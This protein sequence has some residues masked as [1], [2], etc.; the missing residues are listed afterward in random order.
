MNPFTARRLALTAALLSLAVMTAAGWAVTTS[1][2]EVQRPE[3]FNQGTT[4]GISIHS[5]GKVTL[6][7]AIEQLA[8]TGESFVWS[9]T[10]GSDGALYAGT[11]NNGKIIR[12]H[13]DRQE[14]VWQD[15][16]ELEIL[17]LITGPDGHLYAGTSPG[18]KVLRVSPGGEGGLLFETGEQHVWSLVFDDDGRLYAGTGTD[19]KI[20]RISADGQGELFYDTRETNVTA[21][22][23]R[24]KHLYAGGSGG[25]LIYKFDLRGEGM[26]VFDAEEEEIC[27][28]VF[29]AGGQLYAAATSG[30]R[31]VGRPPSPENGQKK[32]D[33][34]SGENEQEGGFFME[35]PPE[36]GDFG[37]QFA[38]P[39]TVYQIDGLGSGQPLWRAPEGAMIFSMTL[40]PG[41]E[42]IVGTGDE[43]RIYS[44]RAAGDWSL[45]AEMDE[46]QVL[47]LQNDGQGGILAGTGNLGAVHRLKKGYGRQGSL[48]SKVHDAAIAAQ[49]GR[50]A[51]EA[52]QPSGT[53]VT[54]VTRSGNS[55][56]PDETWSSW[57]RP[58]GEAEGQAVESPPARFIQW[59]IDLSTS[60][61]DRTPALEKVWL[62]Y[63]Q[64]NMAP[65]IQALYVHPPGSEDGSGMGSPQRGGGNSGFSNGGA[66]NSGEPF[67]TAGNEPSG[68]RKVSW[69][70]GDPNGD[71]LVFTLSFRGQEEEN[72]KLLKEDL[73]SGSYSWDSNLLPD[74]WYLLKLEVSDRLSNPE[75]QALDS[76]EISDPFVI[77]NTSPQVEVQG[78]REGERRYRISGQAVDR[79]SP[80]VELWYSL[81]AGE[82]KPL[83]VSDEIF[84]HVREEFSLVTGELSSGEHIVV[85]KALDRAGNVGVGKVVMK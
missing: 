70:A 25:G 85:V 80:I 13:G 36:F 19:G 29:D 17:S 84:D 49:W 45:V 37:M 82:W 11:G 22:V 59:R 66:S 30:E 35:E 24:G 28:L 72:W 20:F 81:D 62:A 26:M 2:W 75:Q 34:D 10:V 46:A 50:I 44:V 58:Y 78:K 3:Q 5:D 48:E 56:H 14:T 63:L 73:T 38:G 31:P 8:E 41:N 12:I 4:D 9:L 40:G 27:G 83:A 60:R 47:A 53:E 16:E 18:G 64:R 15:G 69:H 43:G 42:L 54:L 23:W 51:W 79:L 71:A 57:S 1:Y 52:R 33:E 21:L 7:P 6:G 76:E 68:V 67:G 65:R 77:D 55:E 61:E 39:S 74:G 32:K